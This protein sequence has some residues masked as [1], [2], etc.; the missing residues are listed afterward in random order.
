MCWVGGCHP[1]LICKFL[2]SLRRPYAT[3]ASPPPGSVAASPAAMAL[4]EA[5]E[6]FF[7]ANV[8]HGEAL[9][10]KYTSTGRAPVVGRWGD[11]RHSVFLPFQQPRPTSPN[12][13][14]QMHFYA[15]GLPCH[16]NLCSRNNVPPDIIFHLGKRHFLRRSAIL[17]D[18][19]D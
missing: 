8:P 10:A 4:P 6:E 15:L 2:G 19:N 12:Q 9:A 11:C 16:Q 13:K 7:R 18:Q 17:V 14:P 5:M 1:L 3:R